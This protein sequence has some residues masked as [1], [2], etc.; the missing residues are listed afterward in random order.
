[1]LRALLLIAG[2]GVAGTGLAYHFG[3]VSVNT[4]PQLV[5]VDDLLNERNFAGEPR[6]RPIRPPQK[7]SRDPFD[8]G[9]SAPSGLTRDWSRLLQI[10]NVVLDPK[11]ALA[12][13]GNQS[14]RY[15]P[16]AGSNNKVVVAV[17]SYQQIPGGPNRVIGYLLESLPTELPEPLVSVAEGRELRVLDYYTPSYD[18]NQWEFASLFYLGASLLLLLAVVLQIVALTRRQAQ[19]QALSE[20]QEV[21]AGPCMI[22]QTHGPRFATWIEM[23]TRW[24]VGPRLA[25]IET[26]SVSPQICGTCYS[27]L[28]GL[29]SVVM[30]SGAV[31]VFLLF[32][33]VGGILFSAMGGL[34]PAGMVLLVVTAVGF[35]L[36][37]GW[38]GWRFR[39]L[40]GPELKQALGLGW[41]NPLATKFNYGV[42]YSREFVTGK[43]SE[44]RANPSSIPVLEPSPGALPARA[45]AEP[46]AAGKDFAQRVPTKDQAGEIWA[47]RGALLLAFVNLLRCVHPYVLPD[48]QLPVQPAVLAGYLLLMFGAFQMWRA[49]RSPWSKRYLEPTL[50]LFALAVFLKLMQAFE[51]FELSSTTFGPEVLGVACLMFAIMAEDRPDFGWTDTDRGYMLPGVLFLVGLGGMAYTVMSWGQEYPEEFLTEASLVF[52]AIL[53]GFLTIMIYNGLPAPPP[54]PASADETQ[55]HLPK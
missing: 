1:M 21:P 12:V 35:L 13:P 55:L 23:Q 49:A 29:T 52:F 5:R 3:L 11:L 20:A 33:L 16:V 18:S 47:F 10:N 46:S 43:P 17:A 40:L 41:W 53:Y 45:S 51:I 27:R 14:W 7:G 32:G 8:K 54:P 2:L 50:G 39:S 26:R 15:F 24:L 34:G 36:M 19:K 28:S 4:P 42:V 9:Y 37:Q 31:S 6:Y 30:L 25:R 38:S 22:C 44:P 48:L